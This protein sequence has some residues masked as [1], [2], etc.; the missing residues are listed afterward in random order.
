MVAQIVRQGTESF[1]GVRPLNPTR[2]LPQIALLLEE[3]FRQDLGA[4]HAW[5]RVPILREIGAT[6]ISTAFMPMPTESLRGF[7]YEENGHIFGNVT[8]TLDDSRER[9]WMIS[10]VAVSEKYRRRGIARQL[11]LAAIDEARAR[12][13]QWLI[14]NVRPWNESAIRLYEGLGFEAVDTETEYVRTR[15][16]VLA[17]EP[18][19]IRPLRN[20]ELRAG[21]MLARAGMNEKLQ[22]FRPP[23]ISEFGVRFEDRLAERTLDLFILQ[24]T[25][26]YGYFENEVLLGTVS[27]HAQRVG[28]PHKLDIRVMPAARGRIEN[29][30]L[31]AALQRLN[32]FAARDISMRVLASHHELVQA[33]ADA[34]F[35]PTR[36]LTLMAKGF[37]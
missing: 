23:G 16:R 5:S 17:Y 37:R 8:L 15:A 24:S 21:Y 2:D 29:G 22:L 36:G 10:N 6:L 9:R 14:L 31:A 20:N 28:T 30:L 26:R 12:S 33:S 19:P 25:E 11:M 3:A 4:L 34:G 27:L 7:V 1:R 18:L 35:V 32:Q 13:A